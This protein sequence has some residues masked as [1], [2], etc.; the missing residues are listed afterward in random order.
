MKSENYNRM[1][2]KEQKKVVEEMMKTEF[3]SPL[4]QEMRANGGVLTRG[5]LT[6][7]LAEHYGFCW[8]VE[9]SVFVFFS[10]N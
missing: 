1:G 6:I 10:K 5:D 2:F 4:L 3:A 9:R 7:R 8:G